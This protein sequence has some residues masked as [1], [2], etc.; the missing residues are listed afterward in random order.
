MLKQVSLLQ[1]QLDSEAYQIR[2]A[3]VECIGNIIRELV[4]GSV[5]AMDEQMDGGEDGGQNTAASVQA[6]QID[7]CFDLVLERFLDLNSHVR[8]KAVT[9][10]TKL[11]ECVRFECCFG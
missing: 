5:A 2:N 10:V 9:T 7:E 8:S 11:L 4:V 3:V 6:K 1:G